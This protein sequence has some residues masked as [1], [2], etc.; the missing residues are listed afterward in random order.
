MSQAD[1]LITFRTPAHQKIVGLRDVLKFKG[2]FQKGTFETA[3][4]YY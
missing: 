4:N 2:L 3:F 1:L